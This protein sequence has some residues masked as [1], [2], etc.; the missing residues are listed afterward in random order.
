MASIFERPGRSR[1]YWAQRERDHSLNMR[2]DES[3][4][5]TRMQATL[6]D[7]ADEIDRE[8]TTIQTKYA[9]SEGL[10]INEARRRIDR[11]DIRRYERKAARYVR[12]RNF[13]E[14][15]NREMRL[16]NATMRTSRLELQLMYIHLELSNATGANEQEVIQR[17]YEIARSEVKR[18]SGI[19]GATVRI[20][21]DEIRTLVMT[22]FKGDYFSNR[23]WTNKNELVS[24]L[25]RQLRRHVTQ[26]KGSRELARQMRREIGNSIANTERIMR[27]ESA[28]V[29]LQTTEKAY[30]NAGVESYEIVTEADACEEC[31]SMEG[32]TYE[33]S[34]FAVGVNTPPFHPNCRCAT[35]P[36]VPEE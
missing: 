28:R 10:T 35:M 18:Q 16:Y 24:S 17:M 1:D 25:E 5:A 15:A 8:I 36:I 30:N 7:A 33:I 14:K 21:T 22:E 27:T 26:G 11:E 20:N 34:R 2:R 9:R 31:Q 29:Q 4:I 19:L 3:E 13:S 32:Q 12:D 23:I 6:L